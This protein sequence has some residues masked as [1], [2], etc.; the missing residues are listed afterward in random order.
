MDGIYRKLLILIQIVIL[1]WFWMLSGF[2]L[3]TKLILKPP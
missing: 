1:G 2:F 3:I